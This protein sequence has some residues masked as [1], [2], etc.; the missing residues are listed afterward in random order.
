VGGKFLG[1][2][3][4]YER[5]LRKNSAGLTKILPGNLNHPPFSES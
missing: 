2:R 4:S 3:K 5:V 1:L